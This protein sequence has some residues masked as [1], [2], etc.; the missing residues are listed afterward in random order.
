MVH[1]VIKKRK[2]SLSSERK[3]AI[4]IRFGFFMEA[5]RGFSLTHGLIL[6][7][8]SKKLLLNRILMF[9]ASVS[10]DKRHRR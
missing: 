8:K 3:A 10:T 1:P 4:I 2:K 9:A 7:Q 5:K 6:R